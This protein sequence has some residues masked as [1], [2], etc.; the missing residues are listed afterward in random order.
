[1]LVWWCG[2]NDWLSGSCRGATLQPVQAWESDV[3]LTSSIAIYCIVEIISSQHAAFFNKYKI[4]A[5]QLLKSYSLPLFNP[6]FRGAN[7]SGIFPGGGVQKEKNFI[8]FQVD[9]PANAAHRSTSMSAHCSRP[10]W[11]HVITAGKIA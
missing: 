11:E 3:K 10:M 2:W 1:V 7:K 4:A 9:Y 8:G 5:I 6:N